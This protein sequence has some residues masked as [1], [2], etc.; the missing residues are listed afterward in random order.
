M[1][2][3][4]NVFFLALAGARR[5]SVHY[6]FGAGSWQDGH[7]LR[8]T[9]EFIGTLTV[10]GQTKGFEPTVILSTMAAVYNLFQ[11]SGLWDTMLRT[12]TELLS[13]KN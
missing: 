11:K 6:R 2:R 12:D 4:W 9:L 3:R 10:I 8:R 7:H 5:C 1:R 13:R